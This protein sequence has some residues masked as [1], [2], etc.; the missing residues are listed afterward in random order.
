MLSDATRVMFIKSPDLARDEFELL[1]YRVRFDTPGTF[2]SIVRFGEIRFVWVTVRL[3]PARSNAV[4][5]NST[6]ISVG[7]ILLLH[8]FNHAGTLHNASDI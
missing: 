3:C 7:C 5:L 4:M 8:A 1:L 6:Y 2:L